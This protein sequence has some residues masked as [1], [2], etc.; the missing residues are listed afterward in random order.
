[1]RQ[2]CIVKLLKIIIIINIIIIAILIIVIYINTDMDIFWLHEWCIEYI[3]YAFQ[4]AWNFHVIFNENNHESLILINFSKKIGIKMFFFVGF[5]SESLSSAYVSF[6][7]P[8]RHTKYEKLEEF[9]NDRGLWT[10]E[11]K[12]WQGIFN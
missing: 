6:F 4:Y 12:T 10:N 8:S 5:G 1:M 3:K 2:H 11:C 9:S 7:S